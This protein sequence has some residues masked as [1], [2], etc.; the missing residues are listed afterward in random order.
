MTRVE[1]RSY[2]LMTGNTSPLMHRV[3]SGARRVADLGEQFR[4]PFGDRARIIVDGRRHFLGVALA[5]VAEQHDIGEGAAD[6]DPGPEITL[7]QPL[8]RTAGEGGTH[9]A[10]VGG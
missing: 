1:L 6:I 2:S 7:Q 10:G 8:S 5:F 9:A 4:E 3:T